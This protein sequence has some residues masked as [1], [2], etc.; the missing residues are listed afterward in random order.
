MALSSFSPFLFPLPGP[1][2]SNIPGAKRCKAELTREPQG[3]GPLGMLG[4]A[5]WRRGVSP[6]DATGARECRCIG[7]QIRAM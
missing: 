6:Q 3:N 2:S 7:W 1:A 5:R 4:G